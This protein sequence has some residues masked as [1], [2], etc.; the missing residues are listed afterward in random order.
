[1][2]VI[3]NLIILSVGLLTACD[4][5]TTRLAAQPHEHKVSKS[6]Y[7]KSSPGKPSAA[8]QMSYTVNKNIAAG[9]DAEVT[10]TFTNTKDVDNLLINLKLNPG[11]TSTDVLQ[12][13]FGVLPSGEAS[14]IKLQINAEN[15]GYYYIYVTATLVSDNR[16]SRSFAIPVNV[17]NVDARKYLKSSG[18]VTVDSQ[19]R[20]IVSMPA[21]MTK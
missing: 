9:E 15:N 18:K 2:N 8:V 17:G 10:M 7:V 1:M 5:G 4:S 14:E 11:L 13:S 16:Q 21:T 6:N 19:G 20:R 3:K 12:H